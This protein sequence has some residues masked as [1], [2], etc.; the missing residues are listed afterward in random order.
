M[1]LSFYGAARMVTGSCFL[2]ETGNTRFL[3]DCGM[4]QG[5]K[6]F[7]ELNYNPF[8]FNPG[9]IDFMLLTHAHIDHSGRIPKLYKQGFKGPIYTNTATVELCSIM[10][11]DSGH[12]QESEVEWKNKKRI[13]KGLAPLTPIY[14][15]RDAQETMKNFKGVEYD[16]EIHPGENITVKFINSGHMLGS[17]FIEIRVHEGGKVNTYL[18]T[19][20]LG[21]TNIPLLK[22]PAQIE[23]V[24]YLIIEST[25]GNREHINRAVGTDLL[26]SIIKKTASQGGN[27]VIPSFAVGRTQE[28]LYD[29]NK[30]KEN[31]L[32]KQYDNIP[33]Y[34]DSPLAI[35]ATEI[36]RKFCRM[37]D[38]ETRKLFVEG[39]DPL[40]FKNLHY[41]LT[42]DDSKMINTDKKSKIIIS[43]SGMCEAGRIKHHLKHNLW[44]KECA[45]VFV[46]YQAPGTL[47]YQIKNNEGVVRI[48]GEEI[49]VKSSIYTVE[50]FSSHADLEGIVNWVA[51]NKRL[52]G[53]IILTHGEAEAMDN[54]KK[55]LEERF[56]R[57]V[58]TPALGDTIDL[59]VDEE[60][61]VHK[62]L[63]S[64]E[65]ARKDK[66]IKEL[67]ALINGVDAS[68]GDF[69]EETVLAGIHEI[70]NKIS[71]QESLRGKEVLLDD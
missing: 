13:R 53:K 25:Y 34:V 31:K 50:G 3:I 71:Q 30:Y 27:I 24:D 47:G 41:S 60:K 61:I 52:P 65:K 39:D 57:E 5:G 7:E 16:Q 44:R 17:S 69:N 66:V 10:L 37:Y 20:D 8:P 42:S 68:A 15:V 56:N 43:A 38:T 63:I 40:I 54:L 35:K 14:T 4:F 45:I 28:V 33:V 19:G 29:I 49:A 26:L 11:E 59:I 62:D 36:F 9:E 58:F 6:E 2:A 12:I 46:G 48:F 67:Y 22:D 51:G 18:F 1:K 32:L 21:N 23:G 55:V 64:Y 70:R